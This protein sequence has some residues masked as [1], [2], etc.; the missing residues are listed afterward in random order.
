MER[1]GDLASKPKSEPANQKDQNNVSGFI[2]E[3]I[4]TLEK[5]IEL[6]EIVKKFKF[7]NYINNI[8]KPLRKSRWIYDVYQNL[9]YAIT[10]RIWSSN[11]NYMQ[12]KYESM[13][14]IIESKNFFID[15]HGNYIPFVIKDRSG[16]IISVGA[17]YNSPFEI[18]T[19]L[20]LQLH[21]IL[22]VPGSNKGTGKKSMNLLFDNLP[23]EYA[24]IV[25]EP[26]P[27]MA[28]FYTDLGYKR[29]GEG[30][31]YKT[32]PSK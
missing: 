11:S 18:E 26:L 27:G 12:E 17:T 31:Y 30:Y 2:Y 28:K 21:L 9:I 19:K 8:T 5:L 29:Y 23:P 10:A 6:L 16:N 3:K 7:K 32:K 4:D 20:Y 1:I 24:G 25:L 22:A 14:P 15:M 13:F